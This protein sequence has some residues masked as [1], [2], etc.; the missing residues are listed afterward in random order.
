VGFVFV[1]YYM[2]V[3]WS[4]VCSVRLA[5]R[6]KSFMKETDPPILSYIIICTEGDKILCFF[7]IGMRIQVMFCSNG[8]V[9]LVYL[10]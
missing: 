2:Y 7:C 10:S 9:V 4:N 6:R 3:L 8:S 5:L 1:F